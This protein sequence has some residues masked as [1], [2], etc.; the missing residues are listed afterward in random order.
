[1]R[2][3]GSL[4]FFSDFRQRLFAPLHTVAADERARGRWSPT[5]G[6]VRHRFVVVLLPVLEDRFDPLPRRFELVGAHEKR[7]LTSE[8][9]EQQAL[10]VLHARGLERFTKIELEL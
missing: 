2:N 8:H 4:V 7:Q 5:A 10:I 3:E 9:I 6:G 1:M